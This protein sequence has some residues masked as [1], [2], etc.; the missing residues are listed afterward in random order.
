[1]LRQIVSVSLAMTACVVLTPTK[2]KAA[3]FIFT[4]I[5]EQAV[6]PDQS[7]LIPFA[8]SFD[9]RPFTVT[10]RGFVGEGFDFDGSELSHSGTSL[11]ENIVGTT[12]SNT[13]DIATIT[14]RTL[15]ALEKDG[16]ADFFSVTGNFDIQGGEQGK[17]YTSAEDP[18]EPFFEVVPILKAEPVPEPLT[19]LGAATALGYGAILKRQS[20]KK[21]KS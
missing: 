12:F 11:V 21:T 3:R 18:E 8:I 16:K 13:K 4:P 20:S 17:T 9:P 15:S 5:G 6:A 7:T 2:V 10:F 1:M 14:M 19:M